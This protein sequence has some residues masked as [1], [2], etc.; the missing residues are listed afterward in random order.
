MCTNEAWKLLKFLMSTR[1]TISTLHHEKL[2]FHS[3][4]VILYSRYIWHVLE[5][6]KV[7]S[8]S[9]SHIFVP[10]LNSMGSHREIQFSFS[11]LLCSSLNF[12]QWKKLF[13]MWM[14]LSLPLRSHLHIKYGSLFRKKKNN[15][16][17]LNH[18]YGKGYGSWVANLFIL[19][20][21]VPAKIIF[22]C[23]SCFSL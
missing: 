16:D 14:V 23:I 8:G 13:G 6:V 9:V 12:V 17:L 3:R 7:L 10:V 15:L 5:W 20:N 19:I 21:C 22:I 4:S 2:H 1:N 11:H 18:T